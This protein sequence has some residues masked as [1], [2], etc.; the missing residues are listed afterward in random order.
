MMSAIFNRGFKKRLTEVQFSLVQ[1]QPGP[2]AS[3]GLRRGRDPRSACA[4]RKGAFPPS[5]AQRL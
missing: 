5:L 1:K 2:D 3:S 4:L